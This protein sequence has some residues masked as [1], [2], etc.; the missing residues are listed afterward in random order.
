MV[1]TAGDPAAASPAV[2]AAI[3]S[4][5]R[6]L[7]VDDIATMDDVVAAAL[8]G[9]RFGMQLLSGFA[10]AA[11]LLAAIGT[12]GVM[13]FVVGRRTRE[14]GIRMALGAQARAV[15]MLVV[16][17]GM[18]PVMFGLLAGLAGSLALGRA[19]SSLLYA[20]PAHDPS[21]LALASTVLAAAGL[22]A[23]ILPARLAARIDPAVAL[24]EQ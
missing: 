13:A 3:R 7:L 4:V 8:G 1:R 22:I 18:A 11:L 5:D 2:R 24:R 9:A 14:V 17:Q 10:L 23:C 21:T 19:L 20:V 16:R 15:L 12:Y 6:S